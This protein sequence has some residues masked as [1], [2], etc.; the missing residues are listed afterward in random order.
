VGGR[1][2]AGPQRAGAGVWKSSVTNLISP[3]LPL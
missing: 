2:S 1:S 3:V